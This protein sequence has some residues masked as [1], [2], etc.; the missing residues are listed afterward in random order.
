MFKIIPYRTIPL[1]PSLFLS[2]QDTASLKA[3]AEVVQRAWLPAGRC[4]P[5]V[6]SEQAPV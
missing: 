2:S 4:L 3:S 1:S 5:H 6:A